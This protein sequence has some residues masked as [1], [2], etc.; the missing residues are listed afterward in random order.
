MTSYL[1]ELPSDGLLFDDA[2][3]VVVMARD[4]WEQIDLYDRSVPT[5]PRAGRV[6]RTERRFKE[7]CLY[8]VE[9]MP[10]HMSGKQGQIHI[11]YEVLFL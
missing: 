4:V 10:T 8:V 11:P 9:D 1:K 3:G 2:E 5:A 7:P 6:Y